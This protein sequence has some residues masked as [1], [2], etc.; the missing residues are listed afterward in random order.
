MPE[1]SLL[2]VFAERAPVF[3]RPRFFHTDSVNHLE[4]W[5][6]VSKLAYTSPGEIH[7]IQLMGVFRIILSYNFR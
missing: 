3:T 6:P 7:V 5:T 2:S 1:D 4:L